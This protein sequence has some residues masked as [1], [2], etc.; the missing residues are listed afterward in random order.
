MKE[1]EGMYEDREGVRDGE[2]E[3]GREG[4]GEARKGVSLW[5]L[6]RCFREKL[7]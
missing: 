6:S 1:E 7:E 5:I 4:G 2:R 3:G